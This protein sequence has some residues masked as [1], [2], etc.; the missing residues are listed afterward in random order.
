LSFAVSRS[1]VQ[2]PFMRGKVDDGDRLAMILQP[3]MLASFSLSL[4]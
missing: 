2:V 3:A 4:L 1:R